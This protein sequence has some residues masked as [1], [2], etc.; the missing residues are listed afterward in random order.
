M[1]TADETIEEVFLNGIYDIGKPSKE[2]IKQA[3]I[4]FAKMHVQEALKR[5]SEEALINLE[6]YNPDNKM[7]GGKLD[8]NPKYPIQTDEHL[9]YC[10][11]KI[12][13]SSV[14]NSYPL[15]NIK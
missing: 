4:E 8:K 9:F 11:S 13:E 15:E 7:I 2:Q 3:V 6:V 10:I 5:A 14:T 12:N 1:K